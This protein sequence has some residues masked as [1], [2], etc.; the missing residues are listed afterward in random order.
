MLNNDSTPAVIGIGNALVDVIILLENDDLLKQFG[1]SR[2]SMTLVD[3]NLSSKI[4]ESTNHLK[5]EIATGGSV[6]NSIHSLKKLGGNCGYLGKIG[7]DELGKIF[8]DEFVSNHIQT[9]L[10]TSEMDTGRVM[11]L[12]STD[13]ERTMAT[14]LG[15]AAELKPEELRGSEFSGYAWLYIEGYLVFNQILIEAA[16]DLARNEGLKIAIDLSSYNVVEANLDFLKRLI[17]EKVD[18]VF[19]NEEEALAF[20]GKQ[21]EFALDEIASMC[22]IAIVKIGKDGS[23]IRKGNEKVTI[24]SINAKAIDTTGAGDNYAAGFFYGLT[25]GYSLEKCGKIAAYLSGKAVEVIG[26]KLPE[27][28]WQEINDAIRKL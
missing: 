22:E 18:M 17:R 21:P 8:K 7:N 25:N 11:G 20:T 16:I 5:K 9:H 15:A 2:G 4:Y 12:I 23:L 27:I 19:A 3:S 28:D 14:F 1:L 6:A 10:F 24:G 26:A 13:S